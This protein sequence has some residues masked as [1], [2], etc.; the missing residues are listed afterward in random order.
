MSE[1]CE[2]ANT[3]GAENAG[4]AKQ[5][6]KRQTEHGTSMQR[7]YVVVLPSTFVDQFNEGPRF[8]R[9]VTKTFLSFGE[10][11]CSCYMM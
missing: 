11:D 4:D 8:R 5:S 9:N 2:V 10:S 3:E 7:S 1:K 6:G